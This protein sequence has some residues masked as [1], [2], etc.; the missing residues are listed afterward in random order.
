MEE[1]G[2]W[3]QRRVLRKDIDINNSEGTLSVGLSPTVC[4]IAEIFL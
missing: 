2:L 1:K 4:G 3:K